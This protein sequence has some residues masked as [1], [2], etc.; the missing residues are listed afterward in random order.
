MSLYHVVHTHTAEECPAAKGYKDPRWIETFAKI[1]DP[2]WAQERRVELKHALI[3]G[4][5]HVLFL[6]LDAP[7]FQNVSYFLTPIQSFGHAQI[8]CV[9]DLKELAFGGV[10]TS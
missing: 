5:Q 10:A 7:D 2:D 6:I 9:S 4:P 1:L 8:T 3:S